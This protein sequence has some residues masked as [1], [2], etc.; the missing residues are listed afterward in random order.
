MRQIVILCRFVVAVLF[1]APAP[2]ALAEDGGASVT[3]AVGQAVRSV[4]TGQM[5]AFQ[6]DD[7]ETAFGFAAPSIRE[8]FGD[9]E[10]FMAMVKGGYA[11]VYRPR[12]VAFG[13]L[14]RDGETVLQ[15]VDVVGPDG[16]PVTAMYALRQQPDGGWRITGV[17][18]L[19]KPGAGA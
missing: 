10:R 13:D 9:A 19:P 18:M 12:S 17:W 11:A 2:L 14:T 6:N 4:I 7:A 3:A 5:Q 1:L 15:A 16:V 8:K